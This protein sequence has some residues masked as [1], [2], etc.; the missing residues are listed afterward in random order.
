MTNISILPG[1]N[2][3]YI[4]LKTNRRRIDK[5]NIATKVKNTYQNIK[6]NCYQK[7]DNHPQEDNNPQENNNIKENN[8]PQEDNYLQEDNYIQESDISQKENIITVKGFVP[9]NEN[10]IDGPITVDKE[11]DDGTKLNLHSLMRYE[12][13][14]DTLDYEYDPEIFDNLQEILPENT[15]YFCELNEFKPSESLSGYILSCPFQYTISEV[16]K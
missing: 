6:E 10:D 4:P 1:P 2:Q 3:N 14:N 12:F 11:N 16:K 7:E 5:K 13:S 8:Y 15:N 9:L